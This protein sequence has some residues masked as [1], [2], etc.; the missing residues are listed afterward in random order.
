MKSGLQNY[1]KRKY[2]YSPWILHHPFIKS[3]QISR[4]FSAICSAT[5]H[6]FKL[7]VGMKVHTVSKVINVAAENGSYSTVSQNGV[8]SAEIEQSESR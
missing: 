6:A 3:L 4:V 7:F 2:D 8:L 5:Q 1:R